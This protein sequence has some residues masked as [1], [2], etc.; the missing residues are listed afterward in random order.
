MAPNPYRDVA[1]TAAIAGLVAYLVVLPLQIHWIGPAVADRTFNTSFEW[2]SP[3]EFVYW[4]FALA[5]SI[6][7]GG[8]FAMVFPASWLRVAA[9]CGIAGSIVHVL[10]T[11]AIFTES[12]S[13]TDR[14]WF[15]GGHLVPIAGAVIGGVVVHVIHSRVRKGAI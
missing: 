10:T 7:A 8:A 12:A 5:W 2:F 13:W 3:I 1:I 11:R 14:L 9:T 15:Y 4:Q 6:I